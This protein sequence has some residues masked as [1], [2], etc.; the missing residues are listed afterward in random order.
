MN[1]VIEIKDINFSYGSNHV[2]KDVNLNID[3]GEFIGIIGPNA[4]GKTT[5]IKIMLGLLIPDTGSVSVLGSSP[6]NVRSR[7]GYVAQKPEINRQFPIT[8]LD[9]ILL[10][11]LGV[12]NNFGSYSQMD[13]AIADEILSVLQISDLKA[14]KLTELSGGQL[15][16]VWLARA[17]VCQPEILIL[18]EPTSNIDLIAEE[19]I[20]RILKEYNKNMTII[21]ISHD[22]A[23]ISSFVN[24]VA[25]VNKTLVC[26]DVESISGKTIEELYGID[27]SMIHHEHST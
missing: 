18:D 10:G 8:V 9:T 3:A 17:L 14:K 12:T 11:R 27:V 25:C 26:H 22:V 23:F 7:M 19:N 1:S 16:R 20:F 2:L 5:L 13:R 6:E 15:Q 21:V 4:A 24:R